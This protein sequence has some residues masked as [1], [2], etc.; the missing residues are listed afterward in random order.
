[1]SLFYFYWGFFLVQRGNQSS[2][3]GKVIL[4]S[5]V[6]RRATANG[7][8][9]VTIPFA[10]YA[11][12]RVLRQDGELLYYLSWIDDAT[13]TAHGG[14]YLAGWTPTPVMAYPFGA[15]I[16]LMFFHLLNTMIKGHD[17]IGIAWA[18]PNIATTLVTIILLWRTRMKGRALALAYFF[19][20]ISVLGIMYTH[21]IEPFAVTITVAGLIAMIRHQEIKAGFLLTFA[22]FIKVWPL[23]LVI[24]IGVFFR[25][26]K[27]L[28][29]ASTI[30]IFISFAGFLTNGLPWSWLT[31]AKN[32]PLQIESLSALPALYTTYFG[33]HAYKVISFWGDALSGPYLK[34][35]N[36][37]ILLLVVLTISVAG[38]RARRTLTSPKIT[39]VHLA[40]LLAVT[41]GEII[42]NPVFSGQYLSW[43]TPV[44]CVA[45]LFNTLAIETFI[46]FAATLLTGMFYPYKYEGLKAEVPF[47]SSLSVISIRDL[48]LL[49]AF[50]ACLYRIATTK[51]PKVLEFA[52]NEKKKKRRFRSLQIR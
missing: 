30:M 13:K 15:G 41:L 27:T 36:H 8:M 43:L 5:N 32:R 7:A 46:C 25:R 4:F 37:A 52:S 11:Y 9:L 49:L 28:A 35:I 34:T 51:E 23:A 14:L 16:F 17:S 31:F 3:T 40:F 21:R 20:T 38:W 10:I 24:A 48:F 33:S 1:M 19:A 6:L 39:E 26:W 2:D 45:L 50:F 47:I 22:G 44:I 29:T 42:S 18:I 12:R